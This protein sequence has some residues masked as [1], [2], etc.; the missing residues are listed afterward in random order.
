MKKRARKAK[1]SRKH[2]RVK[3]TLMRA[4]QEEAGVRRGLWILRVPTSFAESKGLIAEEKALR[5]LEYF[6]RKKE[7]FYPKG[8]ITKITPTIHYS[9]EDRKSIDLKVEF[10]NG[11][12]LGEVKNRWNQKLEEKLRKRNRCLIAIPWGTPDEKARKIVQEAINHWE[13]RGQEK[14]RSSAGQT[15]GAYH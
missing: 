11:E 13:P 7:E 9:E 1:A 6:Q 10:Q 12:L 4:L 14:E 5:A 3:K 15:L 8:V 2:H